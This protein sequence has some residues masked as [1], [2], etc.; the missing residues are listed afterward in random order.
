MAWTYVGRLG[1]GAEA[2][3]IEE[4]TAGTGGTTK[5]MPVVFSSGTVI[6]KTGGTDTVAV[7]G[8]PIGT[9]AAAKKIGVILGLQD[10]VFEA[11]KKSGTTVTVGEK[12]GVE[13]S[14][15]DIDGGN[16]TQLMIQVIGQGTTSSRYRFIVLS[17]AKGIDAT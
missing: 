3:P 8:V 15:L 2:P 16:T 14:T 11:Q 17:F 7:V 6:T 13:A 10:V 1:N 9:V 12:Y 5:G 4:Y